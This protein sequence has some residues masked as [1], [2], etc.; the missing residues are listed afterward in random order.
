[1]VA[2]MKEVQNAHKDQGVKIEFS[3]ELTPLGTAGPL[4]LLR[5]KLRGN[6]EKHFFM[7]NSDVAC[8]FPLDDMLKAQL[9]AAAGDAA[10]ANSKEGTI[11]V[12]PVEDP[13][14]Y[15]LVVFEEKEGQVSRFTEKPQGDMLRNLPS[16][17]INAGI[18]LLSK[19]VL[20]YLPADERPVSIEREVF[21]K[22]AD[23]GK[24]FALEI[25]DGYWMDVGQPADFVAGTQLHLAMLRQ[26]A[27]AALAQTT[28][29]FKVEGNVVLGAG[30]VVGAGAVL[31][32]N[33]V[34]GAGVVV[35]AGA[36]V[37]NSTVMEKS[38]VEAGAIIADSVVG[39]ESTVKAGASLQRCY[40]GRDVTVPAGLQLAGTVVCPHVSVKS[41]AAPIPVIM[42]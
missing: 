39:W 2:A 11:L 32:P 37:F 17:C 26:R 9:T 30:A 16:K 23:K 1:M 27:P 13:S 5:D 35:G 7:L 34:I 19:A 3:Y 38:K 31:G 14:K 6:S 21:P 33:T 25:K 8:N 36:V 40:L 28:A 41:A 20:D 24:L 29:E 15:G 22:I 42:S 10:G 12:T 4:I 18:Y